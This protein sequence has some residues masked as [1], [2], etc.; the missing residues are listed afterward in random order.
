[1]DQEIKE[2]L[3]KLERMKADGCHM[4]IPS[5]HHIES[6]A[7][8][9]AVIIDT[10]KLEPHPRMKDVYPDETKTY[11]FNKND[12]REE[13]RTGNE[14]VRI[15]KQGLNKLVRCAGFIWSAPYSRLVRDPKEKDRMAYVAVGGVRGPDGQPYF[16]QASY[17]MDL[18]IEEEKLRQQ[19]KDN[20]SIEYLVK[21]DLLQ[22]KINLEKLCESG[23]KN[24]VV[25]EIL[26][27]NNSYT[28]KSL[29]K[30]FVL[31]RVVPKFDLKDEYTRRLLVN[32]QVAA[33]TGVYGGMPQPFGD[34][35][36]IECVAPIEVTAKEDDRDI[37]DMETGEVTQNGNGKSP[38][39][40]T[41]TE[42]G[43]NSLDAFKSMDPKRQVEVL[44]FQASRKNYDIETYLKKAKIKNISDMSAL[45]KE[46]LFAHLQSLPEPKEDIP[47]EDDIPF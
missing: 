11:D 15:H 22:K 16:V 18:G 42:P 3:D 21:R 45:K 25:R 31:V 28:V 43:P 33:L 44:C 4:L 6:I 34:L 39:T 19:Y 2:A 13:Y 35:K 27:I 38:E 36:A 41:K 10:V 30:E 12:W 46:G 47:W 9:F 1:M 14:T 26:C 23:A 8:G 7:T 5:T 17:A 29:D 24:R 40:E 20:K 37:I 32:A